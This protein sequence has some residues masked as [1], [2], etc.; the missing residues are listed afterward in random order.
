M[1]LRNLFL[2]LAAVSLMASCTK[3]DLQVKFDM[4]AASVDFLVKATSQSG[5]MA[6]DAQNL[7]YNLD[8]VCKANNVNK[9][10]IKSVKIKEVFLDILDNNNTTF[11]LVNWAEAYVGSAGK[12]D[13]ML[14]SKNPVPK[15]G[16][17]TIALDIKDIEL[18]EYIKSNQM[19]FF[20]KGETNAPVK[21]DVPMRA[22]VKFSIVGQL[23]K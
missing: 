22:R 5:A 18:V 12:A 15:D 16:V 4:D 8:S 6:I 1:K 3:E 23:V 2:S 19:S 20:A 11:D 21:T 13:L 14:A 9:D 7:T 10:Q 17:R